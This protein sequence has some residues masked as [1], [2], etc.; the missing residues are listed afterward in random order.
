MIEGRGD[1][2]IAAG[3]I[4]LMVF[5]TG[6][7]LILFMAEVFVGDRRI[8]C[9]LSTIHPFLGEAPI[10]LGYT[11][12]FLGIITG[13]GLFRFRHLVETAL[14]NRLDQQAHDLS[15]QLLEG[16]IF[17]AIERAGA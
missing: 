1:R 13:V 7:A 6:Q 14:E 2:W 11:V 4:W 3:A 12:S 15:M 8:V 5:I 9:W 17:D 16:P 10:E